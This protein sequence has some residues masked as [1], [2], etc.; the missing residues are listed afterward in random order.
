MN[1]A[2]YYYTTILLYYYIIITIFTMWYSS[3]FYR[4]LSNDK[5]WVFL[6][7]LASKLLNRLYYKCTLCNYYFT[8]AHHRYLHHS[9]TLCME[10]PSWVGRRPSRCVPVFQSHFAGEQ[11]P[12]PG[13]PL[14]C[15]SGRETQTSTRLHFQ[16]QA[17]LSFLAWISDIRELTKRPR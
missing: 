12:P 8:S 5:I 9:F 17:G 13:V 15:L 16:S 1:A 7:H 2:F 14:E 11:R 10:P 6:G 4:L 3:T